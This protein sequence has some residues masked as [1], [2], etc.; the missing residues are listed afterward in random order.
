MVP[1]LGYRCGCEGKFDACE[2][3]EC[4]KKVEVSR[5]LPSPVVGGNPGDVETR[6][7]ASGP[8]SRPE[9]GR[10]LL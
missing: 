6:E 10:I 1:V 7:A 4:K 8:A 3:H 2:D 5:L 9:G